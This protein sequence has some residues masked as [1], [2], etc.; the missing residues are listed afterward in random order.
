MRRFH[1]CSTPG[2][3]ELAPCPQHSRPANAP[4]SQR[5]RDAQEWFRTQLFFRSG[6]IC[7]RCHQAPASQAHHV[8][9]GDDPEH[10]LALCDDC[11][12]ALDNKARSIA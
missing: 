1:V 12:R 7:E 11:H 6:G 2:C 3:P 10:G 4:W 5:D 9:P 8:R